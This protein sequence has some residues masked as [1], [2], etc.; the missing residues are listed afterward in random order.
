MDIKTFMQAAGQT[1]DG[2]NVRQA[3]LYTGLQCEELAEKMDALGLMG[4]ADQLNHMSKRFK[5]GIY[6]LRIERA[7][8]EE[9]LDADIDLAWVS[10]ASAYSQGADVTGACQEVSRANHDKIG[11]DGVMAKDDNGKVMKPDGWQGPDLS[12]FV[13]R[14]EV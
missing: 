3:A 13:C 9:L 14:E 4:F 8:P 10:Q 7:D 5:Q 2:F 6:D 1:T 11:A 12:P